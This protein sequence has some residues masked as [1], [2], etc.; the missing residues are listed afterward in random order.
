MTLTD[1][2]ESASVIFIL[3]NDAKKFWGSDPMAR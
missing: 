2:T 1:Q 3:E